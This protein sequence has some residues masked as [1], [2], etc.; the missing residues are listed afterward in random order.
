MTRKEMSEIF[1]LML[2]AWP[3]APML[4]PEN[5]EATINLWT[6]CLPEVD[7]ATGQMAMIQLC[8]TCHFPPSIAQ[9]R[10]A[11][12]E[13]QKKL[14]EEINDAFL[15]IRHEHYYGKANPD[16]IERTIAMMGGEEHLLIPI[17]EHTSRYNFEEFRDTYRQICQMET[18]QAIGDV[19]SVQA[20]YPHDNSQK[21][22]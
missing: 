1:A 3:N 6:L 12:E 16:R 2:L 19:Q 20:L 17:D 5:M 4:R 8:R 22:P 9:M 14:K 18:R 11:A 13:V 10:E 15:F 21:L 7:S